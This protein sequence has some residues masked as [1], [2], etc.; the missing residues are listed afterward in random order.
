M[1][2]QPLVETGGDASAL[3]AWAAAMRL[4]FT[5]VAVAPFG[6]GA[7]LAWASGGPFSL[8]PA[9]LGLVAVFLI[10]VGCYLSGEVY[11][12]REDVETL[13]HG[14]NPFSGGSLMVANGRLPRRAVLGASIASFALAA[15]LGAAIFW[16]RR[17]LLLVGLGAFGLLVAAVYSVPPVR[18]VSR[19]FGE[20]LIGVCYG[21][22]TVATGYFCAAGALPRDSVLVSLP[23]ALTVFNIILINEFPD[24]EADRAASKRNLLQRVGRPA[25][26]RIYAAASLGAA[27]ALSVI[28][29][30]F[31]HGSIRKLAIALAVAGLAAGLAVAVGPL[32]RWRT[33]GGLR[34]VCGGTIV[35]NLACA[36]AVA[37]LVRW[38]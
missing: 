7:F 28:G 9:A 5:S 35:L 19:G 6:S 8:L 18:L 27:A 3:R 14:R 25:G 11:D 17:D 36:A 10:C 33:A 1:D 32:G 30:R 16:L 24:F 22:L 23:G 13:K 38:P 12:Q 4:P 15:I 20:L 34:A 21:W 37:A 26:A 31:A 2:G 29:W